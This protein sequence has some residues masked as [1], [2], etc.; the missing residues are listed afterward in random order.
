MVRVSFEECSEFL[1]QPDL[2]PVFPEL[3]KACDPF[4]GWK[5]DV[6]PGFFLEHGWRLCFRRLLRGGR[7]HTTFR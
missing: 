1:G 4:F 3:Q 2:L 5:K 6:V 7:F